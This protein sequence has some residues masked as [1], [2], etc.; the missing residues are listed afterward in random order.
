M[1]RK[2][3][4]LFRRPSASAMHYSTQLNPR[5]Q[6]SWRSRAN[7]SDR[8]KD[9]RMRQDVPPGI[10]RKDRRCEAR[11]IALHRLVAVKGIRPAMIRGESDDD[12]P[13]SR[14]NTRCVR[15]IRDVTR[16]NMMTLFSR[17]WC[18]VKLNL[19]VWIRSMHVNVHTYTWFHP[20]EQ[21]WICKRKLAQFALDAM[22]MY[23]LQ[24]AR[25][26]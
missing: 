12:D 4:N 16:R 17:W 7:D 10:C 11:R 19:T 15:V 5:D 26:N 6:E 23:K 13:E 24:R 3:L 22:R 18:I 9:R 1:T 20:S 2:K 8:L 21:G 14:D 25:C